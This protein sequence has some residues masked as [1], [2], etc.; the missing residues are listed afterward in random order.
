M[1]KRANSRM[2]LPLANHTPA[3][4]SKFRLLRTIEKYEQFPCVIE[5]TPKKW[6]CLT[7][8]MHEKKAEWFAKCDSIAGLADDHEVRTN[9]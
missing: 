9:P 3:S 2:G 7:L 5:G 4:R 1:S 6:K 8:D